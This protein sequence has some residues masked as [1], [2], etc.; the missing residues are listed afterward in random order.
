MHRQRADPVLL[1]EMVG[2]LE[3]VYLLLDQQVSEGRSYDE[4]RGAVQAFFLHPGLTELCRAATVHATR[5]LPGARND[6][7]DV[8][9]SALVYLLSKVQRA[10]I[11]APSSS[12]RAL[13]GFQRSHPGRQAFGGWLYSVL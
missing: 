8:S 6:W 1:A 13:L 4:A 5:R 3:G 7:F 2:E 10:F 11:S 12:K 9:Q